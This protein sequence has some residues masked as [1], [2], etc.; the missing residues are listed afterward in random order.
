MKILLLINLL[1]SFYAI[2]IPNYDSKDKLREK[3]LLAIFDGA[4]EFLIA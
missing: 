1:K 4:G 3:L 2:E